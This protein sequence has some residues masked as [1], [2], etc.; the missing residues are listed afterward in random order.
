MTIIIVVVAIFLIAA[1]IFKFWLFRP[2]VNIYYLV[3]LFEAEYR[4][5]SIV[6]ETDDSAS[7]AWLFRPIEKIEPFKFRF[8]KLVTKTEA[9]VKGWPITFELPGDPKVIVEREEDVPGWL[10]I[11]LHAV[12][13]E[14]V[15]QNGTDISLAVEC[16]YQP[17]DGNGA[18]LMKKTVKNWSA[19]ADTKIQNILGSWGRNKIADEDV[20]KVTIDQ[21][22]AEVAKDILSKDPN[23]DPAETVLEYLNGEFK[24]H[25]FRIVTMTLYKIVNG[26]QSQ[27]VKNKREAIKKAELTLQESTFKRK[28]EFE[29][30]MA[31]ID[32][33]KQSLDN[34][35]IYIERVNNSK[36]QTAIEVAK[37]L[38]NL[39]GTL[40]LGEGFD[41]GAFTGAKTALKGKGGS[42]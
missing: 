11:E 33:E 10:A 40:V 34:N 21:I 7:L 14:F 18:I 4:V 1:L 13:V 37:E 8:Q 30:G 28:S 16:A 9:A 20:L 31:K 26:P 42:Q 41:T 32:L 25:G 38:K 6:G 24:P 15:T 17:L 23:A 2:E 22:L 27:D 29:L 36:N 12:G 19:F 5:I 39:K 35:A 3:R